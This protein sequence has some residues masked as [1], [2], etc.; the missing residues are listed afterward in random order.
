ME[1]NQQ[2]VKSAE[3]LKMFRLITSTSVYRVHYNFSHRSPVYSAYGNIS[4]LFMLYCTITS[5]VLL[6]VF[7]IGLH[8]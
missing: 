3:S 2:A 1:E 8:Y 4:S 5:S 7:L 6:N